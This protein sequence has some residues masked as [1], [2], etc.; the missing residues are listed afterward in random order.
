ME[1]TLKLLFLY[2]F[3]TE[4]ILGATY[5]LQNQNYPPNIRKFVAD[6]LSVRQHM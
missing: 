5:F 4:L 1:T 2:Y 6:I 3:N